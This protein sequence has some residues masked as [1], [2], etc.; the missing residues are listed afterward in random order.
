MTNK[1]IFIIFTTA[2][3]VAAG[4][5]LFWQF[6]PVVPSPTPSPV[7]TPI[8]LTPT[9]S[10]QA[11]WSCGDGI[12]YNGQDY[13]TVQIGDHCWLAENLNITPNSADNPDCAGETI[14]CY[15]NKSSNCE[16]YGGLYPL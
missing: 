3:V 5:I 7:T 2:M 14:Y 13:S 15:N 10:D 8:P 16:T 9:P 1:L 11:G 6:W 4:V 12:I